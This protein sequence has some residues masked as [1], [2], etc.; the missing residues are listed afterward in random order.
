MAPEQ[1]RGARGKT[2][3]RSDVYSLGATLYHLLTGR[4]PFGGGS[5]TDTL[6]QVQHQEPVSLRLLHPGVPLDLETICLKCLEK[7]P[8]RRYPSAKALGEDLQRWL[9]HEPIQARRISLIS[10][11]GRWTRRN[12]V[13]ATLIATLLF[14]LV[15]SLGL[16]RML[17][18][19]KK[20]AEEAQAR[21]ERAR[22]LV[23]EL[24]GVSGFWDKSTPAI[25]IPSRILALAS[26]APVVPADSQPIDRRT[27]GLLVEEDPA[28]T[29]VGY[30]ALLASIEKSINGR[31]TK[32][33]H[34]E[35]TLFKKNQDAI[36]A[37]VNHQVDLL[38][39]GG[40]SYLKAKDRDP[41]V[42]LLVSQNPPKQGVIFV[43]ESSELR[44]VQDLANRS[45][46][47]GDR[48]STISTWAYYHLIQAG[49][50]NLKHMEFLD[51]IAVFESDPA[52]R[53]QPGSLSS[54]LL[55]IQAVQTNGYDA[56]VASESAFLRSGSGLRA[57]LVFPSDPVWWVAR[58]E[59]PPEL[60]ADLKRALVDL[61]DE[62]I[63]R[64][65]S[66]RITHY[67]PANEEE[68]GRLRQAQAVAARSIGEQDETQ[69]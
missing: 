41:R 65:I 19:E 69:E 39:I 7:E 18:S 47:F 36:N 27:L 4:P 38:K 61:R 13:G 2:G 16:L 66:K 31:R 48:F 58:G 35:M 63:F 32:P 56:G 62:T 5:L 21:T 20:A 1:A 68:L 9:D 67:L 43:R 34:F 53:L 23:L 25:Q 59:F 24:F 29:V 10:R 40:N 14:G 55:T 33:V 37:L 22:S 51:S 26:G 49:V 3:R 15:V 57:I 42:H 28:A 12:P 52:L 54:H 17:A 11:F 45:V 50:T 6:F 30:A 60:E 44:S 46:V 64:G 8:Q